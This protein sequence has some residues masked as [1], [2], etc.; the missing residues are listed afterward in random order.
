M[1]ETGVSGAMPP[2]NWDVVHTVVVVASFAPGHRDMSNA[3][4]LFRLK[5]MHTGLVKGHT[6]NF[7]LAEVPNGGL[8]N[9]GHI[10]AHSSASISWSHGCTQGYTHL[11]NNTLVQPTALG[12]KRHARI[13]KE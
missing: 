7:R 2:E 4:C 10:L 6:A 3:Y 12:P 13:P 1:L 9:S 5:T 8:R 11:P